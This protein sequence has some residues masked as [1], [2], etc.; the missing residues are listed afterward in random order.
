[1]LGALRELG[2]RSPWALA[3]A[4]RNFAVTVWDPTRSDIQHGINALVYRALQEAPPERIRRLEIERPDLLALYRERYDP[5][6][7]PTR[8]AA[9]PD[10]T[11]GREYQRFIDANGIEPL[12]TLLALGEPTNP[13]EYQ[14]RR[15]YKLHDLMHV[16]L[17]V[18]AT[19][20]GEVPI[21]AYSLAQAR[22]EGARAPAMALAVLFMNIALRRPREMSEAVRL[23]ARWHEVGERV[24]W[25]VSFRVE[26]YLERP[27]P[28]V[29]EA[30]L[31][32]AAGRAGQP[33]QSSQ[34]IGRVGSGAYVQ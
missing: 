10:G 21:V 28:E 3:R 32:S 30:M 8:L 7:D 23:A 5:A 13:L 26:D 29:R 31:G 22:H 6:L 15:A 17:D 12:K 14:F 4:A 24:L 1:M 20:L 18:D 19:V 9:L 27:V 2:L 34:S 33:A 16:V 25:H 11:L